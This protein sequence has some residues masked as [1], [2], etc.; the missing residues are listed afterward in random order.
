MGLFAK[1]IGYTPLGKYYKKYNTRKWEAAHARMEKELFPARLAFYRQFIDPN[2]LVFDVGANI[3][4]RVEIFIAC[5]A[6]VI[7]VE[8]QP[9]CVNILNQK[10]GRSIIIEQ[11]GLSDRD[12]EL[13]MRIATDSTV[14]TFDSNYIEETKG[15]FRFTEWKDTIQVPITTLDKLISKHGVPRFCKIDVEGFELQVLKGL[16]TPIPYISIEYIVPERTEA[17]I[18]CITLL[19]NI[20]PYGQFNYSIGESMTWALKEWLSFDLFIK[21][22]KSTEFN[23]TSFGDIYYKPKQ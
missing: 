12:G 19:K 10:F 9:S 23:K 1:L 15:K 11:V 21:H 5:G 4:N 6:K 22:V 20:S 14:S 16:H 2:D 13:T 8:P 7:A 3:G 18:S 17:A